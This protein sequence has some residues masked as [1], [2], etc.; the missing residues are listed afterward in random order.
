M[1]KLITSRYS[2]IALVIISVVTLSPYLFNHS[3]LGIPLI[4]L[5]ATVY[6]TS[7]YT[8][9][10]AW[11]IEVEPKEGLVNKGLF[12]YVRHPLYAGILIACLGLIMSTMS[13]QFTILFAFII[14]P[15]LYARSLIEERLLVK[16]LPGYAEY[17][18]NTK[19]FI[20]KIL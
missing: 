5:G 12:R 15:Y 20:P 16:T 17:M 1:I 14:I 9:G 18:K 19:M 2:A 10:S 11:S 6:I 13:M 7:H 8:M 4:V 3:P